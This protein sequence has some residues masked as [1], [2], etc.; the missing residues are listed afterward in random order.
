MNRSSLRAESCPVGASVVSKVVEG[1]QVIR[2]GTIHDQ[3]WPGVTVEAS[4]GA[5]DLSRF[6]VVA[7]E[8]KNTDSAARTASVTASRVQ[9][10]S[11]LGQPAV[12]WWH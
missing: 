9:R 12:S 6:A 3:P 2:V 5:W 4:A 10:S 8:I 11:S 7:V 1:R